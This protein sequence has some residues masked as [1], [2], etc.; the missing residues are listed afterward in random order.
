[1]KKLLVANRGEIAVR[2]L[3]SA[4]DAGIRTVLTVSEPDRGSV[5]ATMADETVVIGPAPVV[6]S[7]LSID[8]VLDAVRSSGADAVHPGFGF[9]SENADFARAVI[10]A[11]VTWVGPAPETIELMGN[12]SAARNAAEAAGVPTLPGT[13]GA[14][15]EDADALSVAAEIGYPLVV[16]A[17]AGG[18]GRGIRLVTGPDELVSTID[19]ARAEAR[20]AFGDPAVYLE[21]FIENARHVEVQ[22][23]ADGENV[24]HLGDRDCSMQRRHQKLL[25]EAPAPALPNEVRETI[26]S[27]SVELAHNCGY[28]GAGTVEFL[29]DPARGEAAFIEMNTRIQVEH[30]VTEMVTGIDI[31]AEQLRIAD[32]QPLSVRQEDVAFHGH[33]FEAR[34]NA[35]D[36]ANNFM[37]SPGTLTRIIWPTSG[38]V[39][40][41][42]GFE[43]GSAVLPFYDSMIA[44]I[45]VHADDRDAALE[46]LR[47]A[48]AELDIEG[49]ATTRPLLAA[50]AA[51]PEL[52]DVTHHSTFVEQNDSILEGLS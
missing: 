42:T 38:E 1:M 28:Q 19:L 3:R 5:A 16:K 2:V 31:V 15:A 35:E 40:V 49:V 50:L 17:S 41:D 45:I 39:R 27:S 25:E 46:A 43:E 12:K 44:K 18:G 9:L 8:A 22:I 29:F 14:L 4:R 52:R 47:T 34:V 24:I 51:A 20:A 26:R 11:G 37:P 48:L 32:G 36:P 7:Y 23:L 6:S 21:R 13:R 33:A 10:D 30:P